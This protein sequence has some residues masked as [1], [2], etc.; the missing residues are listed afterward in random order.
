MGLC[1]RK[2]SYGLVIKD[3]GDVPQPAVSRNYRNRGIGSNL[4]KQLQN[5]TLVNKLAFLN[6]DASAL[7]VNE[8]L[9]KHGF[10][11]DIQQYE[12]VL[13]LKE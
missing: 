4:I 1:A 11:N 7:E 12:M 5:H 9:L 3:S 10:N 13:Q 6:A 2:T 8:F